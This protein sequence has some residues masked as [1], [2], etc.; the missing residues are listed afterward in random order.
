MC[1][2]GELVRAA[3][4]RCIVCTPAPVEKPR[5]V[6]R[7]GPS[8]AH[9]WTPEEKA[10]LLRGYQAEAS[11]RSLAAFVRHS[12][13]VL[14]PETQLL[15]NWHM[16]VLCD[17]IQFV[18]E[19][20]SRKKEAL[21]NGVEFEQKI[22]NLLVNVPPGTAKSRILSVCAPA[23]AWIKWP[24]MRLLCLSANPKVAKRD[25]EYCLEL[26]ESTW[27]RSTFAADIESKG[28][29]HITS[30]AKTMGGG[31]YKNSV[32]GER[33]SMGLN[34]KVTGERADG[35]LVD[36]PHDAKDAQSE[37]QRKGVI[38]KWQLSCNNRVNDLRIAFRIGIM[39]RLHESDWAYYVLSKG[40]HHLCIP[41]EHEPNRVCE[42]VKLKAASCNVATHHESTSPI[43]WRD[44]R[45]MAGEILHEERFT[46]EVLAEELINL[47]AFGYSGQMQQKPSPDEGGEF[48]RIYWRFFK[49]K[50]AARPHRCITVEQAPAIEL[51][52]L[53]W[54]LISVDATFR[55][56]GTSQ[57][58]M[59]VIGGWKARRFVLDD[60]T[61]KL[62]Y[63]ET[64]DAIRALRKKWPKT[65][66]ILVETKANGD[67]IIDE[68][69]QEIPG[70]IGV[71]PR[72]GKEARAA[73]MQPSVQ[74]LQW[75]LPEG[76]PWVADLVDE[77]AAFPNGRYDDRVDAASQAAIEMMK[78]PD[79]ARAAML[80]GTH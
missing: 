41:M 4:G 70:V 46:L 24:S 31:Y 30:S 25:Y 6:I 19:S 13:H 61:K 49:R 15:W 51:P 43:G 23:W 71:S 2:H 35:I 42:C 17:H 59:L 34:A 10:E 69:G 78:S 45:T 72:G 37:A 79:A 36:D 65:T 50:P 47:G 16:Q 38:E 66:R 56:T 54:V 74:A 40:W 62:S 29:W 75:F 20:W 57:V 68:L 76:E 32:G 80:L 58:G 77:F 9:Q 44:P 73:A 5:A 64:K 27:Y 11:R 14:E 60:T 3:D 7:P 48:K 53:T 63:T 67:A 22:R 12:W 18:I 52:K 55:K 33:N 1:D 21:K 28:Q 8:Q 26:L 39:Q